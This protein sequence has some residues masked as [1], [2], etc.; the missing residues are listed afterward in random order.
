MKERI[1]HCPICGKTY[2]SLSDMYNCA[3]VCE[4][5]EKAEKITKERDDAEAALIKKFTE[6]EQEIVKF[7]TKYKDS[8]PEIKLSRGNTLS[9]NIESKRKQNTPSF[10]CANKNEKIKTSTE[11]SLETFL[12][13]TLGFEETK[14]STSIPVSREQMKRDIKEMVNSNTV[15]AINHL[16]GADYTMEDLINDL[17]DVGESLQNIG[18]KW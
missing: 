2:A 8:F 3:Q 15:E 16:F 13:N 10:N 7:N 14:K 6:L 1:Y 12:K 5:K 9:D 4:A 18:L 17:A 11:D